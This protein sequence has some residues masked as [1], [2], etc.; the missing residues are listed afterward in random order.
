MTK[1]T[2]ATNSEDQHVADAI[3]A[4]IGELAAKFAEP[5]EVSIST[6]YF[7]PGGFD[8]LAGS[9]E[10]VGS[11]RL[12]LGAEPIRPERSIRPLS[13]D[14]TPIDAERARVRRALEG[15]QRTIEEDRDLLGFNLEA[16]ER[17]QRLITWLRSGK[18]DVRRYEDGFLHGKAFLIAADPG[19][20]AGSSNFTYAGLALNEELNLGQYQPD[21][22]E[23]VRE[24]FESLWERS[25]PFDLAGIYDARYQ[26][27]NPY[28]I[29]LRMLYERYGAEIEDEAAA[30]GTGIHLT[31]FQKDGVWRAKRILRE[32]S[33]VLVA[34]DVG[35]G[36]TFIAGEL[37]R[38]AMQDRRQRVL[39]ITPAALRDGPWRAFRAKH[40]LYV[41]CRSYEEITQG[42]HDAAY[43]E[44]AMVV[45]DEAHGYRN[46][47]TQ[48]A[49]ALREVLKG[50][51]PKDLVM[52]TATPVNNSL[53]D[54]Y[55]L[56][57]F[58]VRNDAAFA[59]A[60]VRSLRAHFAEAM[61]LDPDDLSPD[62]LFDILD[63]VAVRRTRHFVKR[64][65]PNDRVELNGEQVP[66]VF[67]EPHVRKVP[68]E[69]DEVLPGF[70]ERFAHALDCA[71][72]GCPHKGATASSP[73]LRLA[74][75]QPSRYLKT[76]EAVTYELQLSGLLRS[77][78]LK[79]SESSAYAFAQTCHRMAAS[80]DAFLKLL[81]EG[82]IATGEDLAEWMATDSD[83]GAETAH[84]LPR[85]AHPAAAYQ[86]DELRADV[87]ADRDLLL[88]LAEEAEAVTL[89]NDPKL[90]A[91]ADKLAEIAK[92]AE[93][94]G[95]GEAQV[96][97]MRKV[98]VFSYFADT[99]EWLE[100]FLEERLESDEALA[101]YRGRMIAV[102]GNAGDRTDAMFG[103]APRTAEAP[104]DKDEDRF[105]LL[106]ATDVLAEGVNLQQARQIVN[107]DLPW[108]PMRLVQRHGRIDRIGSPHSRVFLWCFLP[109]KRLDDLLGLEE[110]LQRKIKQ[111]AVSVG[112]TGE[113]IPGSKI[114]ERVFA[115]TR[116]QI[117]QIQAQDATLFVTGGET[118][119]AFSGEEYRQELRA[120]LENPLTAE[121]LRSLAWGSG[122]GLS[123]AGA[124]PGFVF[125]ARVGDHPE[126]QFRFVP[127]DAMDQLVGDTL[128]SLSYA[129]ATADTPRVL[130]E[131]M[132][133]R[134]YDAWAVARQDILDRWMAATD[135]AN[136]QPQVPKAMRD[137][138]GI[139]RSHPPTDLTIEQ[140]D[141]LLDAIEA[142]YG[143]RILKKVR[144]AMAAS[145]EPLEQATAIVEVVRDLGLEP[146]ESPQP[147]PIIDE[148]DIHLVCWMAITDESDG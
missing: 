71:D 25:V 54:L 51:P 103:F 29:Y 63:N 120:G 77:A 58:F 45:I 43:D 84:Q 104:P 10:E 80:H 47:D 67:P 61:A 31:Q 136:L 118:G 6:A 26:P 46:P 119:T 148:S 102:S 116:D 1:P 125:C 100:R 139:L 33:G 126:P 60:G 30:V 85:G 69:L 27:H 135:P 113:V 123:R 94:E 147:L 8:L 78:L 106:L 93:A 64:Y 32:R 9:L 56:L 34:D 76:G 35:L 82:W 87:V 96:R 122:S 105:D 18:V 145:D 17:A 134:A 142:P 36:K 137:A 52:L 50:A 83:E 114:E 146:A 124:R 37:I 14:L 130:S 38:E 74:R 42:H 28:L 98:I 41:E 143:E 117:A 138:A 95:I 128:S 75:Y 19:V 2:F 79:R 108:N 86:I 127:A 140:L 39:L 81:D 13:S 132:H 20:I 121:L 107:Y 72:G 22:V 97:D 23:K 88:A 112:V 53:W 4:Y 92:E 68:Y 44:Y 141:E 7:N 24:W 90:A 62:K 144:D 65:Y 11:V 21:T 91:L 70:F 89:A 16:D 129:H 101:S 15:H 3:N 73:V 133:A 111:A 109:D 131:Q 49:A 48:R 55:Y 57:A 5:F 66:I 99:V 110:R 12:L 40:N 115:E 59:N